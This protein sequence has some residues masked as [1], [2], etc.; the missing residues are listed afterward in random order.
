MNRREFLGT[1]AALAAAGCTKGE[2]PP[3]P[4]DLLTTNHAAGHRL[5]DGGLPAASETR[6]VKVA[7]VGA[8]LSGLAAAWRLRRA[9]FS[10]FELLELESAP[11]GNARWGENAVSKYPWGSHY[12]P[13]PTRE[14]RSLRLL[15]AELGVLQGDPEAEVARYDERALVQA[16]QERLYRDGTWTDRVAPLAGRSPSELAEW[17]RFQRRMSE[18]Q[19]LRGKDGR[20]AFAIPVEY[21]SRDPALL[22]L[23]KITMEGWLRAEGFNSDT[24]H[25]VAN[26]A[27]RDDF[28]CEHRDASAWAGIHYFACRVGAAEHADREAVLTWP[29]GNG[30]VVR[31]LME[32]YKFALT[33][34]AMVHRMEESAKGVA[35]EVFLTRES[36]SIRIEAERV[37]W[38]APFGF[39]ARALVNAPSA[40]A[41]S[42]RGYDY[43]PWIT[44]NLTLSEP[45][46][47][48][49][50]APLSWDNVLY[51]GP[52]LGYV[53]ATHQGLSARPGPTVLTWY[54]PLAGEPPAV[55][56]KRLLETPRLRWAAMAFAE[57]SSP[58]PE[59][60]SIT[61]RVD[62]FA[63]G[64]AMVRP[65]PGR[66][67][68]EERRTI[69]GHRGRV[70]FAHADASGLSL[71]EEATDRGVMAAESVLAAFGVRS[72]TMRWNS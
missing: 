14:S 6:R 39:A 70:H 53:V 11:G 46:Y 59:M 55:A 9:G 10:D 57:L 16:P 17:E 43:A 20:R 18:F 62:V 68:G 37:V 4:G 36:R 2:A 1:S 23:D 24:V 12:I 40:L 26:Y 13:L 22:A 67:W 71:I 38:A 69:V 64:H 66:I 49:V 41:A 19:R 34:G 33:P 32:R 63:N 15:L 30:F 65:V 25:W 72:S 61:Q 51:D 45:P 28:G 8:G 35:L 56:R 42:L 58:H 29:E 52:S 50:G 44:A 5:R 54:L 3:P 21:S 60:R 48:H 31:E 7:I 47:P 27:C